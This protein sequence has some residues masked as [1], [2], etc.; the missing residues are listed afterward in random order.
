MVARVACPPSHRR[1]D[2]GRGQYQI[3]AADALLTPEGMVEHLTATLGSP[4][5]KPPLLPSIA[6][7]LIKLTRKADV[8]IGNVRQLLE[9]DSLLAAKVLQLSQSA[10]YSRGVPVLSLGDAISRLGLRTLEDLF[11]QTVLSTRVFR[12]AGYEQPLS[13]LMRHSTLTA[14]VARMACRMTSIPDEYAFMCGLLHDAGI[15]AGLLIFAD[16]SVT[17][18]KKV[19]ERGALPSFAEVSTALLAVHE[20]ASASLAQAWQLAPD[21]AV[22]LGHHHHFRMG[23][24]VHPLAAAVC[25]ADWVAS[26]LGTG[27]GDESHRDQADDAARELGFG[28]RE[29]SELLTRGREIADLI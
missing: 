13:E 21:V 5:Y 8:S 18:W 20:E 4:R 17:D 9:R 7:E 25:V 16:P 3:G 15:A 10:L 23:G 27:V 24:R 11:L 26:E 6:I 12:A 28:M 19:S 29:R 14:H 22:V 2:Y 1:P